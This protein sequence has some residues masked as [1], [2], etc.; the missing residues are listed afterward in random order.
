M[1]Q[2]TKYILERLVLSKN[3]TSSVE[4]SFKTLQM[5]M[6]DEEF[7]IDGVSLD[8]FKGIASNKQTICYAEYFNERFGNSFILVIFDDDVCLDLVSKYDLEEIEDLGWN[9]APEEL[10]ELVQD[11]LDT[12]LPVFICG[13]G[14][15]CD[16][17]YNYTDAKRYERYIENICR[18]LHNI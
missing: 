15:W 16:S 3:K 4:D 13:C 6:Q 14:L 11:K 17:R 10:V 18:E 5:F 7:D 2:L 1:K 8:Y 12:K 9:E